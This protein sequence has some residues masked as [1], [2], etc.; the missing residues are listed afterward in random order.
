MTQP[1]GLVPGIAAALM[2]L[3]SLGASIHAQSPNPPFPV[4]RIAAY[5]SIIPMQPA[6]EWSIDLPENAEP[7]NYTHFIRQIQYPSMVMWYVPVEAA[8]EELAPLPLDNAGSRFELWTVRES[9][10]E[11]FLLDVTVVGSYIPMVDIRI[12]SEDPYPVLPRTRADRPFHVDVTIAGLYDGDPSAPDWI[13]SINFMR[14]VQSYGSTGTGAGIDRTQATL[15]SKTPITSNGA[16][17]YTYAMSSVPGSDTMKRRGEERFSVHTL[18][19]EFAPENQIASQFIQIWP[20]ADGTITGITEGQTIG[21]A[22]PAL[23][24]TLNDLYPTSTTWAQ[25]Y[26][27]SPKPGATGTFVPGSS[28]V[29]SVPVPYNRI[30][31]LGN[32]GSV[33]DSDGVWTMEILTLTPF[34][35]DRITAVSFT[36]QGLGMTV[37]GWHQ[38]H[39]GTTANSDDAANLGDFDRDGLPNLVEFAFGLDPKQDSSGQLPAPRIEGNHHI[40]SFTQPA[41]VNGITYGAEWSDSLES[42]SWTPI[43]DTAVP[44]LHNFSVPAGTHPNLFLR[45]KVTGP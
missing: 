2:A 45:L 24:I 8:G 15:L 37:E 42:D 43:P 26:K 4:G 20:V 30:L 19:S 27:G 41:G 31:T 44:P 17:T 1:R 39:F 29:I 6:L 23:T 28:L 11:V 38:A 3:I 10:Q 32:Y 7:G 34:G 40:I 18:E 21:P 12:R 13:K 9:P 33:F 25:V 14:H 22:V 36:M 5:P 16:H 35:T